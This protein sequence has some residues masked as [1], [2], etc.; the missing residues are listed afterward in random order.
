MSDDRSRNLKITLAISALAVGILAAVILVQ[1]TKEPDVVRA[2]PADVV[3]RAD[4]HVLDDAGP[5]APT[6]VEFLDFEC[7]ACGAAYPVIEDLRQKYAGK[8]NFVI[9]YFPLEGHLN[10]R[11]AAH[12]VE[13]AA[14]QGK[15][16][17]MYSRMFTTQAEW[18]DQQQDYSARFRGYADDLGLDMQ[19]YDTDVASSA[20]S[21][22]VE[23][24]VQDGRSAGVSGTPSFFLDGEPLEITSVQS[25]HDAIDLAI[26][27]AGD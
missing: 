19:Q 23:R 22:R 5:E 25:L 21:A 26:A 12:A 18:G 24:D 2:D 11:N 17:E 10:S 13:A 9:R 8:I 6:L 16:E 15:V 4:S 14:R 3:V 7:E 1:T 20:V 27:N